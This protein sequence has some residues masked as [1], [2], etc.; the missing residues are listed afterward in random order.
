LPAAL[1]RNSHTPASSSSCAGDT[2][3]DRDLPLHIP[4]RSPKGPIGPPHLTHSKPSNLRQPITKTW[5]QQQILFR[6]VGL[7]SLG[8][9]SQTRTPFYLVSSEFTETGNEFSDALLGHRCLAFPGECMQLRALLHAIPNRRTSAKE[10]EVPLPV[11]PSCPYCPS[12]LPATSSTR[13]P[14]GSWV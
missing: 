7:V 2:A 10:K 11:I 12:A 4:T 8:H 14:V 13:L 5:R 3:V 1:P 9:D 6:K